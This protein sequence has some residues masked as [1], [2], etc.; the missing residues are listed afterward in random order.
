MFIDKQLGESKWTNIDSDLIAENSYL[1]KNT[2]LTKK[3][4]STRWI[5]TNVPIWITIEKTNDHLIYNVLDLE[6]DKEYYE[7]IP[8][9]LSFKIRDRDHQ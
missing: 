9:T 4:L 8:M 6:K 5:R 3:P 1:Y 2:I 7:T